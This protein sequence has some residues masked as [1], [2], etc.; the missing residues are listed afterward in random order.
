MQDNQQT[1]RSIAATK[2]GAAKPSIRSLVLPLLALAWGA[3]LAA[4]CEAQDFRS[5]E[6]RTVVVEMDMP[7][8]QLGVD[9]YPQRDAPLDL[10]S[11][12]Q[13]LKDYGTALRRGDEVMITK[14]KVNKDHIEV[15]LGGGGY[16]TMGDDTNTTVMAMPVEKSRRERDLQD[17]LKSETDPKQRRRLQR[18]L[19]DLRDRRDR[20]DDINRVIAADESAQK[21]AMVADR[22]Q[23]GGSRFNIRYANRVPPE[24]LTPDAVKAALRRYVSFPRGN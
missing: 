16:G 3:W 11:Y 5:L 8:T 23:Q 7:G 20:E 18:R 9:V 10:K 2:R 13:R 24:A 21:E 15:Q 6:G 12:Q 4:P 19:D 17:Q 1:R 14:V 22:R